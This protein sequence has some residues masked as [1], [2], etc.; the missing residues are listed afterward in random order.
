M[1]TGIL[2]V[3]TKYAVKINFVATRKNPIAN[4]KEFSECCCLNTNVTPM[5]SRGKML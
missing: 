5:L 2:L 3:P 4:V 1:V